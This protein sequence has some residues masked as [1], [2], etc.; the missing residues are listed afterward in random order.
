[1]LSLYQR[2]IYTLLLIILL[3][4]MV[5]KVLAYDLLIWCINNKREEK[6][7]ANIS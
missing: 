6:Y 3:R 5:L 4:V 1:M 2:N 7:K